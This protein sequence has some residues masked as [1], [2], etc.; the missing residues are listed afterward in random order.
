MPRNTV[1]LATLNSS[2]PRNALEKKHKE[3]K[4]EEELGNLE[5]EREKRQFSFSSFLKLDPYIVEKKAFS[6][7]AAK[8]SFFKKAACL[9]QFQLCFWKSIKFNLWMRKW[10]LG[11]WVVSTCLLSKGDEY[12]FCV[13]WNCWESAARCRLI[14]VSTI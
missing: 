5:E 10:M 8:S 7:F 12:V 2:S 9:I 11:T 6:T 4:N 14:Y 13:F 3:K 1:L